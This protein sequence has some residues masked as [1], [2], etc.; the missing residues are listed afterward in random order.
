VK[1]FKFCGSKDID[2]MQLELMI[3]D[4]MNLIEDSDVSV[5]KNTLEALNAISHSLPHLVKNEAL[6]MQKQASARTLIRPELITEVDLGPFKHKV[7][8][9]IPCRKAAYELINTLVI[10]MADRVEVSDIIGVVAK[11]LD[12]PAEECMISCL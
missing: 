12:D 11:G 7:D 1:S 9:G 2:Q 6:K 10:K 3:P 5:Q 4:I 8:A